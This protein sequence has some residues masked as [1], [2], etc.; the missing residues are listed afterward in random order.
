MS[1][2]RSNSKAQSSSDAS[3]TIWRKT[4]SADSWLRSNHRTVVS[5]AI[6]VRE[7]TPTRDEMSM[8]PLTTTFGHHSDLDSR[9]RSLSIRQFCIRACG[10]IPASLAL[11][12]TRLELHRVLRLHRS[13]SI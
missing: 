6:V 13:T 10:G 11:L 4:D 5:R 12:L 8:P 1:S 2:V 9:S 3:A 7:A